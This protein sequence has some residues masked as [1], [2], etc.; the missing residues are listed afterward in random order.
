MPSDIFTLVWGVRRPTGNRFWGSRP[1][2][3]PG[4]GSCRLPYPHKYKL[5]G[6]VSSTSTHRARMPY[7]GAGIPEVFQPRGRN[8]P[9][10]G[11]QRPGYARAGSGMVR[12]V[13]AR[14]AR[15]L[16]SKVRPLFLEILACNQMPTRSMRQLDEAI[17]TISLHEITF[18]GRL[19]I[20]E[21]T[22]PASVSVTQPSSLN[23]GNEVFEA[24]SLGCAM[25]GP[26]AIKWPR[27]QIGTYRN[28]CKKW[29]LSKH[30]GLAG[31][32]GPRRQI[33]TTCDSAALEW[34]SPCAGN[35]APG[36]TAAL[37][38]QSPCAGNRAPGQTAAT[39][40]TARSTCVPSN[41]AVTVC[42]KPCTG[43]NVNIKSRRRHNVRFKKWFPNKHEG[44]NTRGSPHR[45]AT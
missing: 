36:H 34:Q 5:T 25:W 10:K 33:G 32:G 29:P 26:P 27:R 7:V 28:S 12:T 20:A 39:V 22:V 19:G 42:R 15:P 16:Q 31:V 38:W 45:R 41:M 8:R 13:T 11:S 40:S 37:E 4:W 1:P 21:C 17:A 3:P 23:S 43:P 2:D 30:K 14:R 9:L 35:R 6:P 44:T 24:R 18:A